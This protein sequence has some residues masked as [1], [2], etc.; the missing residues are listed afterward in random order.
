M[1]Y[2]VWELDA[3]RGICILGMVIVHLLYDL[4]DLY[5]LVSWDYPPIIRFL[6]AWGGILFV[7][8]SG[9]CATLGSKSVRRGLMVLGAGLLVSTVTVGLYH[10]G[11]AG[12]GIIIY[13]GV[14]HCLGLCMIL[15]WVFKRLP[16]WLLAI[17]SAAII[18]G[19]FANPDRMENTEVAM[20]GA[21]SIAL[22][23]GNP[24]IGRAH[25]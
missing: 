15:W 8:L 11:F 12:K 23:H 1:K 6:M 14:L 3:F 13:F 7:V 21:E 4:I 9:I 5:Q 18:A 20:L 25:V 17:I 24:Q 16:A 22:T 10:F 19:L 2:R